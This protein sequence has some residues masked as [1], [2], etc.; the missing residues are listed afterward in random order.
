[1]SSSQTTA[2]QLPLDLSKYPKLSAQQ[3]GHL[4][5]FYNLS[6]AIDGNWP[7]MGSQEPGQ[8]FLDGYRYQLATMV[9][10]AGVT[11]YHRMPAMGGLFKPLI[12]QLIHKMLRRE[13]WGYW[14]LTSQSGRLVDPDLK[15]L[16]KP[17]ADPIFERQD[18]LKFHWD[19]LFWG[20][21]PET[22]SYDNNGLQKAILAEM[23][24]NKW[25]GVCC[26][27]NLVFIACNQFPIIAMHY[28]DVR[29]GT[30]VAN[31]VL[32][33]YK[34]ALEAKKMISRDDLF[35]DW[36]A[37][38]QGYTATPRS[39]GLTGWSA[40]FMN[41][42]NSD[43]VR[44]GFANQSRGYITN[45]NGH[46]ELQHP[47][48]ANEYRSLIAEHKYS[49][50]EAL[51]KA[52]EY[53]K[54]HR[55]TI[56]FPYNE[57]TL[58]YIVKWLSELGKY[59]EL[60]GILQYADAR[61]QP[62]WENGGLYYLRNDVAADDEGHWTHVDPFSGNAAIGYARLNVEDGQKKMWDRPWT[63]DSL[64]T[65]PWVDGLDLS[66]GVDCLRGVWDDQANAMIITVREWAGRGSQLKLEI[67]NLPT[68]NW[69]LYRGD[70]TPAT[71]EVSSEQ[72]AVPVEVSLKAGEEVDVVITRST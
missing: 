18:S 23:E 59:E 6:S 50:E 44:A 8:E 14:Y 41:T 2:I 45:I 69:S 20:M 24:R 10:A 36:V 30:D 11:H 53:Y 47:M 49:P 26:E 34:A 60:N 25:V 71:H 5:H 19:P 55:K 61:L 21:G 46:V 4:R 67:K 28:N 48:I 9:Y 15:E 57:P 37:V 70:N 62:T 3:A 32:E 58:G 66:Q 63:K 52:R 17:W 7:H 72:A 43:L 29:H 56:T 33:K 38:K 65:Q 12:R 51:R 40:A 68:G 1:M 16:R 22:F 54:E 64:K 42:W 35:Q 39:A 13:V 31:G 27:P